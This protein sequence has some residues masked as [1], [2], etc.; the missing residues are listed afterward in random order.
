M[1]T[2]LDMVLPHVRQKV[3]RAADVA[4]KMNAI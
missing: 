2:L 1:A 4:D 3:K